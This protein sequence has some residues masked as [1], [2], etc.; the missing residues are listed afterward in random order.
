MMMHVFFRQK[1]PKNWE[2]FYDNHET[3]RFGR[4]PETVGAITMS[5]DYEVFG[6]A[7]V[8]IEKKSKVVGN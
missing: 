3:W 6:S 4:K 8:L 5:I 1:R 2:I 7:G